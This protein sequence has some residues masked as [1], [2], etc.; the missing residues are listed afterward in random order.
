MA[1]PDAILVPGCINSTRQAES[2]YRLP[3]TT[4]TTKG[5]R[6]R[7]GR[8]SRQLFSATDGSKSKNK[9]LPSKFRAVKIA[10]H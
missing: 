3:A 1:D 8:E 4:S 5:R 2:N 10:W 6:G 9:K 7:A